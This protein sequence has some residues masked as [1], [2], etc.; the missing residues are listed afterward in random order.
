MRN[1]MTVT[2]FSK[3]FMDGCTVRLS[4]AILACRQ[5]AMGRMALGAG[6]GSMLCRVI[7]QQLVCLAMTAGADLFG[8]GDGIGDF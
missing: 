8:L 6:Q 1:T 3:L 2:A 7:L 5:L 4:M